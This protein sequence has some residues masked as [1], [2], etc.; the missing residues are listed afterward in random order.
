[1]KAVLLILDIFTVLI[2]KTVCEKL[3]LRKNKTNVFEAAVWMSFFMLS[4]FLT[5]ILIPS[6]YDNCF[7]VLFG[8]GNGIC[9][10]SDGRLSCC[11]R[12][13]WFWNRSWTAIVRNCVP[14]NLVCNYKSDFIDLERISGRK[15]QS[16]RLGRSFVCSGEQCVYSCRG[17]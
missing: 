1:M 6:V 16:Y 13:H 2:Q 10:L 9:C 11:R 5:Y 8:N 12:R 3:F 14:V 4:D 17:Y 15:G 7:Y